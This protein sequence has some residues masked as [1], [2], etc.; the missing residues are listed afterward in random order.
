VNRQQ[1]SLVV[2][3]GLISSTPTLAADPSEQGGGWRTASAETAASTLSGKLYRNSADRNGSAPYVVVDRWGVT[4]GYV[5]AV[6]GVEL[7]SC[8]GQQVSLQ[9]TVKTLPG[10][11]MPFMICQQIL[12]GNAEESPGVPIEHNA[13]TAGREA[14][15]PVAEDQ[16]VRETTARRG[17]P[18][19][20]DMSAS[21]A[22]RARALPLREVVLE[23]QAFPAGD[24]ATD[25][26]A[27]S[28]RWTDQ[29]RARRLGVETT[30]YEE[31][32]PTPPPSGQVRRAPAVSDPALEPAPMEEG[33]VVSEGPM[34]GY[35]HA[36]GP[37]SYGPSFG[38]AGCD[39]C[40]ESCC[41]GYSGYDPCCDEPCWGPRAPLFHWGPTG[42][43]VKADYLQWWESGTHVPALAVTGNAIS[44]GT[45]GIVT[46]GTLGTILPSSVQTLFGDDTINN[47]SESGVRIQA[48]MWL[49][50]CATIGLEGEYFYLGDENTDYYL[51]STGSG[52]NG[53][54]VIV[55]PFNDVNPLSPGQAGQLVAF[56]RGFAN[57]VDGAINISVASRFSGAGAR[58]LFTTCRQE[59]CWGDECGCGETYHDRFRADFIAGYRNLDLQDQLGITETLTSTNPTFIPPGTTTNVGG[60]SYYVHDQFNTQN[61]FNGGDL[62][63][64]FAFERNRW[65]LDLFPRVALG[66]THATADI[67]GATQVT[68]PTVANNVIVG[69]TTTPY[70]G[71]LLAQP[72]NAAV[73][74]AGN[75]GHFTENSF[76]V[77]P[78]LDVN[79]GFQF[80]QHTR[81]VVGYSGMYWS[82]VARAGEQIDTSVN[83]AI[84]PS[85]PGNVATG[86]VAATGPTHPQFSFQN[87]GF[88][89]Q[90]V[91]VGIDCRW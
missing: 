43:W 89:A 22:P 34:A 26:S 80:T 33:A 8:L 61:T 82:S 18:T 47:K 12:G 85:S 50:P 63:M 6:Q 71:G 86:N 53:N 30:N 10:G 15:I 27:P 66:S 75:I 58:F 25:R 68:T 3:L 44:T 41:N 49:N 37:V 23:P 73:G 54:P 40:E 16:R 13:A 74:Y 76:A 79:L 62:G 32:I 24:D 11:D 83:S 69:S 9:G 64:K 17:L 39:T 56:P 57:S 91:N 36:R 60:A 29:R 46:G 55:R 4:R 84:I 77:V 70:T 38:P 59:G 28:A 20:D 48:G 7:E 90:G 87:T 1:L 45:A 35:G 67:S 21:P 19:R 14:F 88:W 51:W 52:V 2:V 65:S 72:G 81:V 78:E 5:R 31:N 42:I